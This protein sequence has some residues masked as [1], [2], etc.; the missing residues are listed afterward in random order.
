MKKIIHALTVLA[1]AFAFAV[2]Q[3]KAAMHDSMGSMGGMEMSGS[4]MGA[5][6]KMKYERHGVKVRETAI[7]GYK[8]EYYLL[9]K[10]DVLKIMPG[11]GITTSHHLMVFLAK[12]DGMEVTE[13]KAGFLVFG[14]G[15][16]EQKSMGMAML[17]GFGG[18][19]DFSKPGSY[20]I[21]AKVQAGDKTVVD[22]FKYEV[23]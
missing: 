4:S 8:V 21:T 16:A 6:Q 7:D 14:P 20:K 13:A 22:E 15:N 9:T 5:G 17:G 19:V 2:P 1:M 12:P 23:K 10:A 3:A 18:D 11:T